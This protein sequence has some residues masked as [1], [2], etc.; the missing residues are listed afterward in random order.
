MNNQ[1]QD[2]CGHHD[3]L[4]IL[5]AALADCMYALCTSYCLDDDCDR[6]TVAFILAHRIKGI[7]PEASDIAEFR[8]GFQESI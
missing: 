8:K 7:T 5:H 1:N 2:L 6:E 3:D 4:G